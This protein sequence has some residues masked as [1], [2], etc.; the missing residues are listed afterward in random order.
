MFDPGL[1][2][3]LFLYKRLVSELFSEAKSLAVFGSEPSSNFLQIL[4]NINVLTFN[5]SG[6]IT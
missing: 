3:Y 2:M 6:I 4:V 5:T 1:A